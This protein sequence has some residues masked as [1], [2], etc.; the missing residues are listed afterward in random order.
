MSSLVKNILFALALAAAAWFLWRFFF[1]AEDA[2]LEAESA[3]AFSE[4][5]RETQGFL[6]TLQQLRDISLDGELFGDERFRSLIDHRQDVVPES[7]GREN[8]FAPIGE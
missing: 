7:A 8:P 3:V 6:R 2:A 4:A 1:A 5:A